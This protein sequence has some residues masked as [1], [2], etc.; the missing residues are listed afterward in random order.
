MTCLHDLVMEAVTPG[1]FPV[2][3]PRY[4]CTRELARSRV[5]DP[6]APDVHVHCMDSL[7]LLTALTHN[8]THKQID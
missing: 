1:P 8:F 5:R 3:F 4:S 7:A 6:G 2:S